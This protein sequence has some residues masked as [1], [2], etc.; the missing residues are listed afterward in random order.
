MLWIKLDNLEIVLINLFLLQ[1]ERKSTLK[2]GNIDFK[3]IS[4]KL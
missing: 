4:H 1:E 3:L 2:E